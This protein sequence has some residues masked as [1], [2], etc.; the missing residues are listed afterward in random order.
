MRADFHAFFIY[1]F[2]GYLFIYPAVI[3]AIR[4][5]DLK[6]PRQ[7]LNL[8]L[9]AL[10]APYAGFLLYHSVLIKRC[11]SGWVGHGVFW[12][13]FEAF[14]RFG[15]AAIRFLAPVIIILLILGVL[16]ILAAGIFLLRLRRK[17][18]SSHPGLE[19]HV[20]DILAKHCQ[21]LGI[22][23]P[24]VLIASRG[25]YS[26]I[27]LGFFRPVIVINAQISDRLSRRELEGMLLHELA[28]IRRFDTFT[29]WFLHI[30]RDLMIFSPFSVVLL[31]K[32]L[33]ERECVCDREA[34][35][36]MGSHHEYAAV[37]LKVWR[38]LSDA[39]GFRPR[40]GVGFSGHNMEK[41][42]MTL[43]A[44][45]K[46]ADAMPGFLYSLLFISLTALTLLYLGMIC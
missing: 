9:L 20:R 2:L 19:A 31:N 18:S 7:R 35:R 26:A 5:F 37:L 8:Y 12:R 23:V 13:V 11:R 15:T 10:T 29:G 17:Q 27:T 21:M 42:V 14:C 3:M 36:I 34:A 38:L 28:H 24:D 39:S 6:H 30:L 4:L 43:L 44:A 46:T 16:R 45:E 41:R 32:Y 33:F 22:P 25:G 1:V 40:L